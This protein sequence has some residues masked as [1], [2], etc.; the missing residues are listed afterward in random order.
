MLAG[1]L[2]KPSRQGGHHCSQ[3]LACCF[4]FVAGLV[5][6]KQPTDSALGRQPQQVSCKVS[7]RHRTMSRRGNLS[8]LSVNQF[9]SALASLS[10]SLS[11][12]WQVA[13]WLHSVDESLR[14]V[15]WVSKWASIDFGTEQ[16]ESNT[17]LYLTALS[18]C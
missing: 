11:R 10:N 8:D 17:I 18:G 5:K 9:F 3:I 12:S 6:L 13:S 2:T 7:E 1:A 15:K 16:S 14:C 4:L